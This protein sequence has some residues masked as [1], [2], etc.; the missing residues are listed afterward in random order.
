MNKRRSS[1]KIQGL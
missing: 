1:V